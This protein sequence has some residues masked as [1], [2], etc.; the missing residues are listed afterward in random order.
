MTI[1]ITTALIAAA[2]ALAGAGLASTGAAAQ[3]VLRVGTEAAYMPF[4]GIDPDGTI[5]GY[6]V[7]VGNEVCKRINRTCEFMAQDWDGIIPQLLA[8]RYDV[9]IAAMSI[10][11]ERAQQI[12][13]SV[14]YASIPVWI[15]AAKDSPLA[16]TK[17]VDELRTALAGMTVGVQTS[18]TQQYVLEALNSDATLQFY[19]A[20]D[21]VNL[22]L[23]SGRIDAAAAD[24]VAFL[25]FLQSEDGQ[26]YAPVGPALTQA[27][28]PVLGH[29]TGMGFRKEDTALRAE[30]DAAIE[31]MKADGT[32][33]TL[34][35]KWFGSDVTK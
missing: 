23:V 9:I 26:A 18:T 6:D 27:D 19:T 22:D 11:D 34:S 5:V 12:D 1:R 8:K 21:D 16:A 3:E 28:F 25:P 15:V 14:P 35:Q 30:V 13:F 17:T 24:S 7:D 20:Q 29:G 32:L 33:A 10:T 31:A 2:A 4:N